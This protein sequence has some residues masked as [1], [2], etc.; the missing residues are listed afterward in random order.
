MAFTAEDHLCMT[1]ALQLAEQGLYTTMPNPRVGCVIVKDGKI[2]GEGAHL[3]AGDPHAEVFALRQA[4]QQARGATLYVTL[5]PCNHIGRTPPCAQAIINAGITTVIAAMQDPNP[6]VAGNGLAHLQVNHINVASGLMQAQA[7]ALNPGFISRMTQQKPFVRSKI[8]SSLDGKSAL[9]N[10]QS[11]WITSEAARMD[12]QHWRARSCAILTGIGTVLADNPS[13]SVRL[14][15]GGLETDSQQS[16]RQAV[17]Q[18]LR[19]PL[20]QPLKVIVDSD[21]RTP[22]DANILHGGNVIIAFANDAQL[23][24]AQLLAAGAQ[25]LCLPNNDAKVCLKSLLSHLAS[26]E[27]NEVLVEGGEGLNGALLAAGLIDEV[28]IYYA[29][30]LMG[31]AAKG[32][33]A[34]PEITQM[35]QAIA[36]QIID[37]RQIGPDIR[38]R[39]K[40]LC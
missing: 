10:G 33:F 28:I 14:Q 25:L 40:P 20:R 30:K 38:L 34:L 11:Q 26:Q 4:G 8:A 23:K 21:L 17:H 2:V 3:K 7:E 37:L 36:L 35:N 27:I 19:Q 5:E 6:Q 32:L 12:V 18:R 15:S 1:R 16:L 39:A 24:S 13:M 9:N 22:I 29:P 31:S